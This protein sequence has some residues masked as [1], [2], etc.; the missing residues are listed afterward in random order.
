MVTWMTS[1]TCLHKPSAHTIPYFYNHC[2]SL[3]FWHKMTVTLVPSKLKWWVSPIP[4]YCPATH[5]CAHFLFVTC[6]CLLL[7]Y[8]SYSSRCVHLF[9]CRV[10]L[11]TLPS[12]PSTSLFLGGLS[13]LNIHSTQAFVH[14]YPLCCPLWLYNQACLGMGVLTIIALQGL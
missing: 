12:A 3:N 4:M 6:A 8:S 14:L 11:I 13:M 2:L 7:V 10:L 1:W 5:V 9:T